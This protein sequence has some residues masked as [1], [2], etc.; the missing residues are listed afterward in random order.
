M[1]YYP[2][3][4][5][6]QNH[7]SAQISDLEKAVQYCQDNDAVCAQIAGRA[8][9]FAQCLLNPDILLTYLFR[10]LEVVHNF[11]FLNT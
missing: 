3:L 1:F 6:N 10:V 8:R 4:K 2:L 9:Q 11:H 7:I 5:P